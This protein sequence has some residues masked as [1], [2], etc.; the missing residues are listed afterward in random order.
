MTQLYCYPMCYCPPY[1]NA[2]RQIHPFPS[3]ASY[4]PS[5]RQYPEVDPTLLEQSAKSMQKLMKEASLVLNKLADS[6][7]FAT[8]V[9]SAAQ[10]SNKK[11]VDKLIQSTG[12]KSKVNTTFNP[13]G[14]NMR[15]SSAIGEAE[16]CHLTIALRWL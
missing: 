1:F 8:K 13:D 12:I 16:C 7:D 15:L 11:E 9:M 14:I 2:A 6:K 5:I 4:S 3:F 10:Q